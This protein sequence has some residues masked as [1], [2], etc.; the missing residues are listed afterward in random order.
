MSMKK[1]YEDFM[2]RKKEFFRRPIS[3]MW[4]DQ[5]KRYIKPF[6]MFGNLYFVGETWVCVYLINTGDGLLLLDAGNF[7]TSGMLINAIWEVGFNPADIKW[8]VLSHGHVDHF[9]S[10][11]F[12]RNMFGCKLYLGEPDAKMFKQNPELSYIQYNSNIVDE[13]FEPDV[14]IRDGDVLT[15]GKIEMR[16][17]SVPGH[18]AGTIA[19]FLDVVDGKETK[20]VGYYGGFG[21]NTLAKDFLQ[22]IGDTDYKMRQVYLSSL[23]KVMDENVDIF[24]ANHNHHNNIVEKRKYQ[25]QHPDSN[26]YL[27]PSEWRKY[28]KKKKKEVIDFMNNPEN[29]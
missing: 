24:L 28:L 6:Q 29:N 3:E 19:C 8:V 22:E 11:T 1:D 15:F 23:E 12:L 2:A 17:V 13:L 14:T 18:S 10:A 20:R 5:E 27:D 7:D 16:F 4:R 26:P 21:L 25:L 9:G